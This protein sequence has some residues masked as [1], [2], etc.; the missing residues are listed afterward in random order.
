MIAELSPEPVAGIPAAVLTDEE[1]TALQSLLNDAASKDFPSFL[2][3]LWPQTAQQTY[4]ISEFHQYI[5]E[6]VQDVWDGT[7]SPNQ[8]V[9]VA[10]QHGKSRL[11]SVRAVAWIVGHSPGIHV[12]LTGF[13]FGL[14]SDF[15]REIKAIVE[16]EAYQRIFPGVLPTRGYNRSG[17][18]LFTN[19][20]SIQVTSAGSKL[21][22]RRVDWLIVD[23]PHAGRAEAESPTARK[24][25]ETWF[26][27]D[28]TSRLAPDAKTFL[29]ST[30]WHQE[31]LH[32]VVTDPKKVVEMKEAGFGEFNF[33]QTNLKAI[34]EA[35]DPLGR[36]IGAALFP[37]QRPLAF[38]NRVK[39]TMP[40]YEWDSQYCGNPRAAAGDQ[41]DVKKLRYIVMEDVPRDIEWVR[42]WDLA[43]TESTAADFTAGVLTAARLNGDNEIDEFYII[44]IV[45]GQMA[46]SRMRATVLETSR[47]DLHRY[48]CSRM[49]MEAVSGFEAV[50][51]DVKQQLL[52]RVHVEKKNF[53]GGKLVR[54]QPWLNLIEAGRVYIVRAPWNLDFILELEKFPTS[55]RDDQIDGVSVA[56]EMHVDAPRVLI[57]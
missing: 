55:A 43:I 29:I 5:A 30:R 2:H 40:G 11:L 47:N 51:Q 57:A 18:C 44:D 25:V 53:K 34:A 28:C 20:S 45:K 12:A 31:D 37:E 22:G 3:V 46:W 13:S 38:L 26:Y 50:Y 33:E 19:R 52:G 54:A 23:D 10:P 7:R 6:L 56:R 4:I 14:L 36:E 49:G 21:T 39:V 48:N 32:G 9:S 8:S 41:C 15:L 1:C 35:D 42:G 27:A 24:K 16:S 17:A